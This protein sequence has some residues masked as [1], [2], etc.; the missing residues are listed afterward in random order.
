M[1]VL[2]M[3]TSYGK[4][5]AEPA[6]HVLFSIAATF[7]ILSLINIILLLAK[8]KRKAYFYFNAI[9][10]LFPDFI[11]TMLL[12][13]GVIFLILNIAILI[14]LRERKANKKDGEQVA[15]KGAKLTTIGKEIL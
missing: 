2:L 4:L 9:I 7:F 14:T 10:Q 8:A 1:S 5:V 12:G 11:L 6:H 13:I 3:G 15:V